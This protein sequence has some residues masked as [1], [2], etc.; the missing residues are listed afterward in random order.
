M[1][2]KCEEC[3]HIHWEEVPGAHRTY[4]F[5]RKAYRVKP[6]LTFTPRSLANALTIT[7]AVAERRL[8]TLCDLGVLRCVT[9]KKTDDGTLKYYKFIEE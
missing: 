3:G 6:N 1:P 8:D 5:L 7:E 2:T 9:A 4:Q